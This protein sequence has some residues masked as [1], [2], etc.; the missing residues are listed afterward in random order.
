MAPEL[1]PVPLL[2][3]GDL[4]IDRALAVRDACLGWLPFG[5]FLARIGDPIVRRWMQRCTPYAG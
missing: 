2:E 3:A 1:K 4:S 5:H